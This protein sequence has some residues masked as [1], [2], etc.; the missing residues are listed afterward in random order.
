MDIEEY[1]EEDIEIQKTARTP[2]FRG[3]MIGA[4]AGVAA[5]LVSVAA[6]SFAMAGAITLLTGAAITAGFAAGGML[7]GAHEF[8]DKTGY[9]FKGVLPLGKAPVKA[10]ELSVN[11]P[12]S[13][14][15][16]VVYDSLRQQSDTHHRDL[17]LAQARS[18]LLSLDHTKAIPH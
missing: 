16:T 14:I 4:L 17:V 15:T 18:A 6:L 5:G 3:L 12:E 13:P 10:P 9:L 2:R 8:G 1:I 11:S 7:Y